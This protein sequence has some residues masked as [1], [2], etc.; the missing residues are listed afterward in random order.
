MRAISTTIAPRV[1]EVLPD[2]K[3]IIAGLGRVESSDNIDLIGYVDD[4][5]N[6]L[7][8]VDCAICPL[9]TGSGTRIKILDYLSHGVPTISTSK[10]VEGLEQ[11]ISKAVCIQD[12][13]NDFAQDIIRILQ[14]SPAEKNVL[15]QA[16]IDFVW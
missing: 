1:K 14:I 10:G 3:F 8:G 7:L 4:I 11:E 6:I 15:S 13:F 9:E 12:D 16:G 5:N 2:T